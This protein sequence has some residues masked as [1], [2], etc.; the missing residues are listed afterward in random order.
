M[1]CRRLVAGNLNDAVTTVAVTA[2]GR[3]DQS[4]QQQRLAMFTGQVTVDQR[5]RC[6]VAGTTL[7]DL[8]D[9]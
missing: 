9:R 6:V 8:V 3:V 5:R 2:T 4:G 7:L 1:R